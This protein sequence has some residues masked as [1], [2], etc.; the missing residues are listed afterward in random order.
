MTRAPGSLF[1]KTA[2]RSVGRS[3]ARLCPIC[4]NWLTPGVDLELHVQNCRGVRLEVPPN[5]PFPA[6]WF[7]NGGGGGGARAAAA[8]VRPPART[9]ATVPPRH[10]CHLCQRKF[11]KPNRLRTHLQSCGVPKTQHICS[12]CQKRFTRPNHVK[13]HQ[14]ICL[15]RRVSF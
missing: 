6:E 2:A 12:I 5:L 3:M 13:N 1:P 10:E 7:Q 11:E 14:P 4:Y 9:R 8:G 15:K